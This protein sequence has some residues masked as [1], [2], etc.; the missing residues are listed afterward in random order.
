MSCRLEIDYH[1]YAIKTFSKIFSESYSLAYSTV[2]LWMVLL[3]SWNEFVFIANPT[4]F[5]WTTSTLILQM[6]SG[7]SVRPHTMPHKLYTCI[8]RFRAVFKRFKKHER[9][10]YIQQGKTAHT[11]TVHTTNLSIFCVEIK[12]IW[13][14]LDLMGI[15][16]MHKMIEKRFNGFHKFEKT[17]H[18]TNV[19]IGDLMTACVVLHLIQKN[20]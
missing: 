1:N 13:E 12:M 6:K 5:Y 17:D 18:L 20:I 2:K 16:M 19:E 11:Y 7:W 10:Q 3:N 8:L 14:I 4:G 9:R 15:L